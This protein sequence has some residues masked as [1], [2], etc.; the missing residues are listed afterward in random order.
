M[1]FSG[2]YGIVRQPRVDGVSSGEDDAYYVKFCRR[3]ACL[4]YHKVLEMMGGPVDKVHTSCCAAG[5]RLFVA[6]H[7]C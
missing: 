1:V 2:D 5:M 6:H 3:A 4:L 7:A